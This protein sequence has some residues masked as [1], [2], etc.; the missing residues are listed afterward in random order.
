MLGKRLFGL[1]ELPPVIGRAAA[2][3]LTAYAAGFWFAGV[4][5][6]DPV[7]HRIVLHDG[8]FLRVPAVTLLLTGVLMFLF[9]KTRP[10]LRREGVLCAALGALLTFFPSFAALA[11]SLVLTAAALWRFFDPVKF[12]PGDSRFHVI[13]AVLLFVYVAVSGIEQQIS[14]FD[15]LI[16]LHSDWGLYFSQYRNLAE[17]PASGLGS[18][19]STGNHFNPAVNLVMS[20]LVGLWPRAV[21]VFVVNSLL[22]AVPVLLVFI[23][24][25]TLRLPGAVCAVCAAA[26]AFNPLLSNQHTA[27]TYG[28]HPVNFLLPVFL[29]FCIAREKRCLPGMIFAG[30]FMCGIKETVF[31]FLFGFAVILAFRRKWRAAALAAVLSVGAFL[32]VT[33][34]VLPRIDGADAYFQLFQF[35]SFGD[36]AGDVLLAP[37]VSPKLVFEKLFNLSNLS[38][39]LLLLLPVLPAAFGKVAFLCAALPLLLGVLLRDSY[40]GKPNIAQ[41]Y[42]VE[43]TVWLIAALVYGSA[44]HFRRGRF[45]AGVMIALLFGSA[46]GYYF[47]GRTPVWGPCSATAVRRSPDVRPLREKIRKLIPETASVAAT[48]KWAGQLVETHRSLLTNPEAGNADYR[49]IDFSDRSGDPKALMRCRD[50]LLR[51]RSEHPVATFNA[52]QCQIIVFKRGPGKW[53]MPFIVGAPPEKLAPGAPPFPLQLPGLRARAWYVPARRRLLLFFGTGGK[54]RKDVLFT[55]TLTEGEKKFVYRFRWGHGLVPPYAM[56]AHESFVAELPLPGNWQRLEGL[57]IGTETFEL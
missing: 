43:I 47:F 22:L 11:A 41:W 16:L 2:A 17:N 9:E 50:R 31:V 55:V 4:K 1:P 18:W 49:I 6:V 12:E 46:S 30:L 3:L 27:L 51:T 52:R 32:L 5:I 53:E 45:S 56:K 14:A 44:A 24:G 10:P 28:Y 39:I 33:Q 42:G 7:H 13:P 20:L 29:L 23:L 37:L 34:V 57:T 19:C 40:L 15:R 8:L 48:Q 25:R 38:F 26:T 21:T 36:T 54:F 35:R